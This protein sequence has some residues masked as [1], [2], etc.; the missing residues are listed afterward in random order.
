MG[1]YL[2]IIAINLI[3]GYVMDINSDR[4]K[5][6]RFCIFSAF[7]LIFFAAMRDVSVGR[8]TSLFCASYETIINNDWSFYS[9]ISDRY[10][11][12]F[13]AL[14]KILGYLSDSPQLLIVVT[15]ICI[16]SA[17]YYL[18]YKNSKDLVL[19]IIIF[20]G[21][22]FYATSLNLMRQMLALSI[23]IVGYQN[24]LKKKK[25][26]LYTIICLIACLFHK[27]AIMGVAL[28][29]P[30]IFDT[31]EIQGFIFFCGLMVF[32]FL[33]LIF[34]HIANSVGYEQYLGSE[35]DTPNY[36][37]AVLNFVIYFIFYLFSIFS[38]KQA[39]K[40]G[41]NT[42]SVF[43]KGNCD[44]VRLGYVNDGKLIVIISIAL[45][46]LLL[47]IRSIIFER[48]GLYFEIFVIILIPNMIETQ[49]KSKRLF[50]R[51]IIIILAITYC[52]VV[53]SL[54]PEWTSVVP[55]KFFE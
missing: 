26:V 4:I 47:S 2:A 50:F 30:F 17:I 45:V 40:D 9:S 29:L 32:L 49:H 27:S 41:Y 36:F 22:Q 46:F 16:I 13:F 42:T 53:L 37:A 15:S 52:I 20:I 10:E 54:R 44:V 28:V 35:F 33:D 31:K 24:F 21:F 38:Y 51:M 25:Y 5:R 55:Y 12:G 34:S 43:K 48:A 1:L 18:V 8:D 19:S 14:C 11:F 39:R 6:K 7:I 23:L 3:V